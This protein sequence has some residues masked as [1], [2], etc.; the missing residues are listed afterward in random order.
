MTEQ[1]TPLKLQAGDGDSYKRTI[2]ATTAWKNFSALAGKFGLNPSDR[3]KIKADPPANSEPDPLQAILDERK[4]WA[5]AYT[6]AAD[7]RDARPAARGIVGP[8]K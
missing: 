8:G 3:T 7:V 2:E 1:P 6:T 4:S 5:L